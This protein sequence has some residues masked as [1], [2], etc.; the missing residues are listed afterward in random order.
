M[1][2]V[3]TTEA[4]GLVDK[5]LGLTMFVMVV[6]PLSWSG[7]PLVTYNEHKVSS[8]GVLEE[9]TGQ[10]GIMNASSDCRYWDEDTKHW[11]TC[12]KKEDDLKTHTYDTIGDIS[13]CNWN[14]NYATGEDCK[15]DRD[16]WC[17]ANMTLGWFTIVTVFVVLVT[18][19]FGI[20]VSRN[21]YMVMYLMISIFAFVIFGLA[22]SFSESDSKD[23]G[24]NQADTSKTGADA[25][26]G[27]GE[28]GLGAHL[29]V[30]VAFVALLRFMALSISMVGRTI[31]VKG[32][33]WI[34]ALI[35]GLIIAA[36]A[37]PIVTRVQVDEVGGT[38]V[39]N[40]TVIY[41][42]TFANNTHID[43]KNPNHDFMEIG[44]CSYNFGED[45]TD[46]DYSDWCTQTHVS[47][48]TVCVFSVLGIGFVA[49]SYRFSPLS[50]KYTNVVLMGTI[51]ILSI[52][53]SVWTMYMIGEP[54]DATPADKDDHKC[55]FDNLNGYDGAGASVGL[56]SSIAVI[57]LISTFVVF[58]TDADGFIRIPAAS[59]K[60]VL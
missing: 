2:D 17:T 31:N 46:C 6:L 20:G 50:A 33:A 32:F 25:Y 18:A 35:L 34:Y 13:T 24:F 48:I 55:G 8:G 26:Y 5:M 12:N 38:A 60:L 59:Y 3:E 23:C 10:I 19:V 57:S 30:I 21:G 39:V 28:L 7:V 15:S 27:W 4:G 47:M 16:S 40:K 58:F 56:V 11:N 51:A 41:P 22:A 43:V 14:S 54:F 44:S 52:M 49:M 53:H 29:I 1:A 36:M 9:Y 37:T 45:D 42:F